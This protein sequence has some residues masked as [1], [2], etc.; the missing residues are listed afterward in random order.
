MQFRHCRISWSFTCLPG[1]V[2]E[3][4]GWK[5]AA[6]KDALK[7]VDKAMGAVL[8]LYRDLGLIKRTTV[9]AT[10]LSAVGETQFSA[11]DVPAEQATNV[12]LV[13]WIASGVGIKAGHM[14]RQPVSILDTGATVMRALGLTTYMEWES[15]P[16]EEIFKT[17]FTAAPTSPLLQ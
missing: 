9:F 16:V 6:Y 2:G 1:R 17:A 3:A 8:D 4:Q 13:P 7:A 11:G 10:S 15:Q 12:P 5:S 14:I